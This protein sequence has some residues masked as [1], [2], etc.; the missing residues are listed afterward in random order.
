M[1]RNN[2]YHLIENVRKTTTTERL[3][4]FLLLYIVASSFLALSPSRYRS[5]FLFFTHSKRQKMVTMTGTTQQQQQQNMSN[6]LSISSLYQ[7]LNKRLKTVNQNALLHLETS[8][9]LC[10]HSTLTLP[11]EPCGYAAASDGEKQPFCHYNNNNSAA[12]IEW[13]EKKLSSNCDVRLWWSAIPFIEPYWVVFIALCSSWNGKNVTMYLFELK[14]NRRIIMWSS[15]VHHT[16]IWMAQMVGCW[17]KKL[18]H[19]SGME[20]HKCKRKRKPEHPKQK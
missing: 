8:R 7:W 19:S 12:Q 14:K 13:E 2:C 6:M 16:L 5:T 15:I 17:G 11:I 9:S 20:A 3:K 4:P 1:K 18:Q 10:V